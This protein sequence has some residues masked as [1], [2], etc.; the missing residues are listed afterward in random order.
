MRD[1]RDIV[2][3]LIPKWLCLAQVSVFLVKPPNHIVLG[4]VE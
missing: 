3:F 4:N 1:R 2:E